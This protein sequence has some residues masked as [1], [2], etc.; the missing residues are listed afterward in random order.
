[1]LVLMHAA[2]I[3]GRPIIQALTFSFMHTSP[4]VFQTR[5]II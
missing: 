1:M 5:K 2:G 3:L 4:G